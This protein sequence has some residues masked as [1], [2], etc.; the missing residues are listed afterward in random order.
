MTPLQ[1][2]QLVMCH[3][4]ALLV[5]RAHLNHHSVSVSVCLVL[6]LTYTLIKGSLKEYSF[7]TLT[8]LRVY[9]ISFF[10]SLKFLLHAFDDLSCYSSTR[11]RNYRLGAEGAL[12]K[13]SFKYNLFTELQFIIFKTNQQF[14]HLHNCIS[15]LTQII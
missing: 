12:G 4:T 7:S 10:Y 9:I 14:H 2:C 5:I 11:A 8:M 15:R 6:N 3:N 1:R 13:R